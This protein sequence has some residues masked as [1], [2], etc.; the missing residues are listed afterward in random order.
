[1][2][3]NKFSP[4]YIIIV[5]IIL[6]IIP[7]RALAGE[8]DFDDAI[9]MGVEINIMIRPSDESC[10]VKTLES[11]TRVGL[12]CEEKNGWYRMIYGNYRGYMKAENLL[13]PEVSTVFGNALGDVG[14]RGGPSYGSAS[15]DIVEMG[16]GIRIVDMIGDWYKVQTDPEGGAGSEGY[17]NRKMIIQT[18]ADDF[19]ILINKGM[20]GKAVA[21]IHEKL[22]ERGFYGYINYYF[23]E[24]DLDADGNT[25]EVIK[26]NS[27]F[28]IN[29]EHSIKCFQYKAGIKITGLADKETL[30]LLYSGEDI[31]SIAQDRG[32]N[33]SVRIS[34][35]WE[36][37]AYE[38]ARGAT[39]TVYDTRA[40]KTYKVQRYSG[41]N[42]ADV[43]TLTTADTAIF[44]ECFGG[45]R[46]WDGR[47]IWMTTGG[48]TYAASINGY[49]HAPSNSCI[50]GN[51]M[52]GQVCM[53]F[54]DSY[55]HS[56]SSED[57]R[58]SK[59]VKSAYLASINYYEMNSA[60]KKQ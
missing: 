30:D 8:F 29:T 17:V 23:D 60:L 2:K 20:V 6:M 12:F 54:K 4:I 58:H 14:L 27:I 37:V 22:Y 31:H 21:D 43:E 41:T 26:I 1:M 5:A 10:V 28:D 42:H 44:S 51:G 47:A 57:P 3:I 32:I 45:K 39:A 49:P 38:F 56:S 59:M 9:T 18:D 13:I 48:T 25:R 46:T 35:W 53:H 7:S 11:G 16:H 24:N 55:G 40:R 36:S 19:E 33:N 52:N 34:R 50:S 15:I